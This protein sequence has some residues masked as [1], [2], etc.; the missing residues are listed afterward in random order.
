MLDFLGVVSVLTQPMF[1]WLIFLLASPIFACTK[2]LGSHMMTQTGFLPS[3]SS[4]ID[5]YAYL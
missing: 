1:P 4:V 5:A 2:W 3:F